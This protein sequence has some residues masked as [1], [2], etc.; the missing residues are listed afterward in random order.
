MISF[1]N[2][3]FFGSVRSSRSHDVFRSLVRLSVFGLS[4]LSL[5]YFVGQTEPKAKTLRLV[6]F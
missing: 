6:K 1:L 3:T 4:Q 5:L 2:A